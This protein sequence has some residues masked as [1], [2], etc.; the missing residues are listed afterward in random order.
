V[1]SPTSTPAVYTVSALS[2]EIRV[3]LERRFPD[4]WVEGEL[5]NLRRS[6]AG[7]I[8]FTLKDDHAQIPAVCFRSQAR[9][10]RFSPKDGESFRARG[11]VGTYEAR[12]EYQ[13]V[14]DILEPAGRGALQA[15]FDRLREKLEAEGLFEERHKQALPMAPARIGIVTSPGS[16]ALRD[17]LSVLDRRH[18]AMDIVIYP[19]EVQGRS[20]A[21]ELRKG[22]EYFSESDVDVVILARGGGSAED[23]APFND[24][25]LA[26]AVF[27]CSRPVISAVGHETD[28]VITDFV[29]DVR[30]PTPS[31]GAEIVVRT[32]QELLGRVE[33][34]RRGLERAIRFRLMELGRF[35]STRAGGRGFAVA[36]GRIRELVQ[37]V[38][39]AAFRLA[40]FGR[41][42]PFLRAL[43]FRLERGDRA[44]VAG[45]SQTLS[46]GRE[47]MGRLG[48]ALNALSPL[49]V[50]ERGYA[51][52][53]KPGGEIVRAASQVRP[54]ESVEVL[55]HQGILDVQVRGLRRAAYDDEEGAGDG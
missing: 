7:H 40:H 44:A 31:V 36:E 2:R 53:R 14:V 39:D 23:L 1:D 12:G 4:V 33:T 22:I 34:S 28:F 37:R 47:R 35:L 24:E 52:C 49:A 13:I 20:A 18:G 9:Y 41:S 6:A 25:G 30:A 29:A 10:L 3:L 16:A 48:E 45:M 27:A 38:D 15:A 54:D 11:R 50:L 51:V 32:R 43:A 46:R 19:T 21:A 42:G 55:L 26:R 8:Y 5:S 17:I